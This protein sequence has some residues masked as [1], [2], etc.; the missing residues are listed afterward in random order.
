MTHPPTNLDHAL[1]QALA[2]DAAPAALKSVLLA[3]ARA[4]DGRAPRRPRLARFLVAASLV[5]ATG[6]GVFFLL[7]RPAKGPTHTAQEALRNFMEVHGLEFQGEAACAEACSRWSKAKLGF[8]APLPSACAD[9]KVIGG[10]A[11]R[12][13]DR[14][15][16]HFLLSEGR[17]L[18]VFQEPLRGAASQPGAALAVAGGLQAKAWNEQGRGYVLVEQ[19]VGK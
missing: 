16:A 11:C 7:P 19:P 14:P 5:L 18:Y 4:R 9:M 2:P 8:E 12:V 15:V 6:G 13:D 3:E 17:A 1:R 10:R